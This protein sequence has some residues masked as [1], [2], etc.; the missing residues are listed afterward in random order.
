MTS[1]GRLVTGSMS[2]SLPSSSGRSRAVPWRLEPQRASG[3]I[4]GRHERHGRPAARGVGGYGDRID[5][6]DRWRPRRSAAGF[7]EDPHRA[8]AHEPGV[9]RQ[10]L[11]ELVFAHGGRLAGQDVAGGV[12]GIGF[13][14]AAAKGAERPLGRVARQDQLGADDLGG[15]PLGANHRRHREGDARGSQLLHAFERRGHRF[16]GRAQRGLHGDRIY[17]NT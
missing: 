10:F 9:P 2:S 6:V 5:A 3:P 8:A 7:G 15:A 4:E 16:V 11:G 1:C 13:H 12:D 17:S 14:T